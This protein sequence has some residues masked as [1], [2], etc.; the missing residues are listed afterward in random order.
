MSIGTIERILVV[1]D[2]PENIEILGEELKSEYDVSVATTGEDALLAASSDAPPDL[3]LLDVMMPDMDGFEVCRRLKSNPATSGI[4]VIFVT[5]LETNMHEEE[6]LSLGAVDYITKPFSIPIV[7]A[8]IS[9]HLQVKRQCAFLE[10]LLETV[11]NELQT[12]AERA[13]KRPTS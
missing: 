9:V 7:R 4:S 5:A 10:S 3:I 1:D 6:G 12:T 8:R 2:R 13:R 11:A